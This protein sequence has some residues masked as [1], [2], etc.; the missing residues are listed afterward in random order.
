MHVE[1]LALFQVSGNN[2]AVG[3]INLQK[4]DGNVAPIFAAALAKN[5]PAP[6][7]KEPT[8]RPDDPLKVGRELAAAT[9]FFYSK[10]SISWV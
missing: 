8:A 6:F 5:V 9:D 10:I 2:A 4:P 7:S 3:G 1:I